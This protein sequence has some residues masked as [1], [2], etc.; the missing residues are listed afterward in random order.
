MSREIKE[1]LCEKA[2]KK[3][4]WMGGHV[5]GNQS[6]ISVEE[7]LSYRA[8]LQDTLTPQSTPTYQF[9]GQNI[10]GFDLLLEAW[11]P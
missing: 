9:V 1:D 10:T 4:H 6:A 3:V 5:V 2:S 7:I 8:T 11:T